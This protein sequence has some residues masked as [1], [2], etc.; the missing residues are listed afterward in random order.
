MSQP[1]LSVTRLAEQGFTV[2]LSEQPTIIHPNGLEAKLTTKEGTY[3]L[4]V[5]TKGLPS[6][7]KLDICKTDEGIKAT[8]SPITLTPTGA[9]WVTHYH[10]RWVYNNQ[11][12]L[13]RIHRAKRRA[14]FMPDKTCP[15]PRSQLEDYRR[16]IAN[17]VDGTTEDFVEPLHSL[18]HNKQK[19]MLSEPA[20]QGE[21]WFK[22]KKSAKPPIPPITTPSSSKQQAAQAETSTQ[23]L[24]QQ[25]QTAR[26]RLTGKQAEKEE[27]QQAPAEQA[28]SSQQQQQQQHYPET[29]IP[30]PKDVAPT[31]DYWIREGHL[32]KRVHIRSRTQLYIPQQ[33]QDGPDVTKL[34]PE[35]T[36]IVKPTSGSR[37]YRIDDDWITKTSA[38]L[39]MPWTGS[40]NFE[41]STLYKEEVYNTD[42]EE[43]QQA[44]TAKGLPQPAQPTAQERAEHELTHMPFRS[45]CPACVANKGRADNHPKQTSKMPVVQFDFC[46]FKTAGEQTVT[47]ILTGIDVE[48]GMAMA[49]VVSDK[50]QDFQ[51]HVQCIQSFLM[52]CGRVQAVLNSTILQSDQE[53]HLVALLRTTAAKMGGNIT[54]RQSPTYTSQAQGTV[55]RFHRTLMGQVR[56]LRA[57]LQSNYDRTIT[58]KHPIVPWLVRHTAFLIN[59]YLTHSDGNKLLPQMEQR[60]QTATL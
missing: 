51:Y 25:Q 11:G 1:I 55:E 20:W 31:E 26:R 14:T 42:E 44:K 15:V 59:R 19:R 40:T 29:S 28:M 56:T 49:T 34:I 5:N 6:N 36:T 22:V 39:N 2:H 23:A 54:V 53:E 60:S 21:T 46:Y 30:R 52:E 41:E 37:P 16:T 4:P 47:P 50:Q 17:K 33:T 3:F 10:D 13:V 32:W 9:T 48:T 12:F 35:R 43:P 7:Y 8:I 58:S 24:E 38:T 27:E 45:W 57:Q 18:D